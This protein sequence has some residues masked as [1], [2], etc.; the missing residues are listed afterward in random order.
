MIK[1]FPYSKHKLFFH[2]KPTP[3]EMSAV[4]KCGRV[5]SSIDLETSNPNII[6]FL[7]K[8]TYLKPKQNKIRFLN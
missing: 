1:T 2:W 4:R 3:P 5:V 8:G 7:L 6:V